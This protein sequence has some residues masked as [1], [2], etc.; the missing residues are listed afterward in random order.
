MRVTTPLLSVDIKE[1]CVLPENPLLLSDTIIHTLHANPALLA[2][3]LHLHPLDSRA[4]TEFLE[5]SMPPGLKGTPLIQR[6]GAAR[7]EEGGIE[8]GD[9][10]E[11]FAKLKCNSVCIR[12]AHWEDRS[13]IYSLHSS[14]R[15]TWHGDTEGTTTPVKFHSDC[16]RAIYL[17]PQ[18]N[19]MVGTEDTCI[20]V[21]PS[22]DLGDAGL[23]GLKDRHFAFVDNLIPR[24]L[25][26]ELQAMAVDP[27]NAKH[28]N[29]IFNDVYAW[30]G[31]TPDRKERLV[32]YPE[33]IDGAPARTAR[34]IAEKVSAAMGEPLNTTMTWGIVR[35][36]RCGPTGRM[37]EKQ[38]WH[39]DA[40]R[41]LLRDDALLFSALCPLTSDIPDD[42]NSG[43]FVPHSCFGLPDPWVEKP[44]ALNLGQGCVFNARLVH[45]GGIPPR[46]SREPHRDMFYVGFGNVSYDFQRTGPIQRPLWAK[47]RSV[48]KCGGVGC[49]AT[50]VDDTNPCVTIGCPYNLCD[51]CGEEH[52]CCRVCREAPPATPNSTPESCI[53]T[54]ISCFITDMATH[55]ALV[56]VS[57]IHSPGICDGT[58]EPDYGSCPLRSF[59]PGH[60]PSPNDATS[61]FVYVPPGSVA[62]ARGVVG[63]VA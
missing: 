40:D 59:H 52:A 34:A 60:L 25:L 57:T 1:R 39:R 35:C 30:E 8:L 38:H 61:H 63:G 4:V 19:L 46:E 44:M 55:M 45:R 49:Y 26:V 37:V 22:D 32:W 23:A 13:P 51:A 41:A 14:E 47:A 21:P 54:A 15:L 58:E 33:D 2:L 36:L 48:L 31:R 3:S 56:V 62:A 28:F 11:A 27:A 53:P 5:E 50:L 42:G 18:A 16:H 7:H 20:K 29:P 10:S 17:G 6:I 12:K 24:D 43:D 9:E